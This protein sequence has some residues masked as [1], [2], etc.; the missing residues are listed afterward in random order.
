M[1][2]KVVKDTY[3]N[4]ISFISEKELLNKRRLVGVKCFGT[5]NRKMFI[6]DGCDVCFW[7]SPQNGI[8]SRRTNLGHLQPYERDQLILKALLNEGDDLH[9][10]KTERDLF[11]WLAG[12]GE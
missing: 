1:R 5:G 10:F 6:V 3:I 8:S 11:A 4:E 9:L 12:Y 7:Y 2:I